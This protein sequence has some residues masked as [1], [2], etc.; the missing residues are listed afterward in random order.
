MG[1]GTR[2]NPHGDAI[3]ALDSV[4]TA[5]L[6]LTLKPRITDAH[7]DLGYPEARS[8]RA[9]VEGDMRRRLPAFARTSPVRDFAQP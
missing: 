4:G 2:Y 3:A 7:R 8:R 1:R 9:L 5:S 6:N